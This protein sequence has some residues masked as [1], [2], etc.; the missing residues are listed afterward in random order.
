M[1][2]ASKPQPPQKRVIGDTV[3][4]GDKS[5]DALAA[6]FADLVP[7]PRVETPPEG[8]AT[9]EQLGAIWGIGLEQTRRRVE[10]LVAQ[11]KMRYVGRFRIKIG[12]RKPYPVHHYARVR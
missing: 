7:A 4:I 12:D 5:L 10:Q 6:E 8:A 2:S 9:L 11:K 1:P 3:I